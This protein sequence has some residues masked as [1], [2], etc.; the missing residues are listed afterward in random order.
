MAANQ[1]VHTV[2]ESLAAFCAEAA[3]SARLTP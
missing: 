1:A 2:L 3:R